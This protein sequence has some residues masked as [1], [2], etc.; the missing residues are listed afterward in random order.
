[1]FLKINWMFTHKMKNKNDI[2]N[3]YDNLHHKNFVR[4]VKE[5]ENDEKKVFEYKLTAPWHLIAINF[6]KEIDLQGK[7]VLEVGC[8]YGSLSVYMSKKGAKVTGVDISSEAIKISKRN[9]SLNNQKIVFKQS[10]GEKLDFEDE[11]F[12]LVVS[13]EVLEHI[14][15]YTKAIDEIIRVTKKS[16]KMIITTPNSFNLRGLYL[17]VKSKQPVEN[18]FS[19]WTVMKEFKRKGINIIKKESKSLLN[20]NNNNNFDN[21]INKI[22]IR[23]FSLRI[24]FLANK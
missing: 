23:Y 9:A 12:D 24:G 10:K 20:N 2:K 5:A 18:F 15:N 1:M 14:P 21:F 19:Y 7:K 11:E 16:G 17:Y 13:C 3:S 6:L 22:P 4:R 8:G